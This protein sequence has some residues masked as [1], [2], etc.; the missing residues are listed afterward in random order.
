MGDTHLDIGISSGSSSIFAGT[1]QNPILADPLYL[2]Y[3]P[4]DGQFHDGRNYYTKVYCEDSRTPSANCESGLIAP[5]S[6]TVLSDA[7]AHSSLTITVRVTRV[8]L[9]LR[10]LVQASGKTIEL[11]FF[12]TYLASLGTTM[13]ESCVHDPK[14]ALDRLSSRKVVTTS[15]ATPIALGKRI[16]ITF[17]H[18]DPEAQFLCCTKGARALYQSRCCLNCAVQEAKTRGFSRVHGDP[19]VR[20]AWVQDLWNRSNQSIQLHSNINPLFT[21]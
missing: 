12:D 2:E 3:R 5:G 21:T 7:G 13:A 11:H 16:S 8:G 20:E 19:I 9:L 1:L 10:T 17:T 15:V 4:E 6:R 14:D 18:G